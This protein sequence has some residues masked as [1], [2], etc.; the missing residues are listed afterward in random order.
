[1]MRAYVRAVTALLVVALCASAAP[2]RARKLYPV[3]EA[4]RDQSFWTFRERLRRAV[5]ERD[6]KF[7]VSILHPRV[8]L[9]FGGH[10]GVKDFREMWLGRESRGDL[11][12]ELGDVLRLGGAFEAATGRKS[13]CAPY[14][15]LKFPRD[16]DVF[17]HGA[18][19]GKNVRVRARPDPRAPVIETLSYDVVK[20]EF[21][22]GVG[23]S[24]EGAA[25]WVKVTTPGGRA[26]YV[27]EEYIRSPV[28]YRACFGKYRGRWLMTAFIAGD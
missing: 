13:F 19:T 20:A 6:E 22:V 28:D 25:G 17:E 3:D 10:Q 24:G 18:I 27:A 1:M 23:E 11:W 8:E 5:R 26:G 4:R 21:F 16:A 9:S 2:T 14:T 7:V 15:F 12:K